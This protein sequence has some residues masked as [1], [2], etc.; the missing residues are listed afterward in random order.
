[1]G[2]H[3]PRT[4]NLIRQIN[5]DGRRRNISAYTRYL[6]PFDGDIGAVPF[7]AAAIDDARTAKHD[8]VH[9]FISLFRAFFENLFPHVAGVAVGAVNDDLASSVRSL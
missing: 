5:L 4:Q 8:V 7:P 1:M 9:R 2:V 6:I 3:E